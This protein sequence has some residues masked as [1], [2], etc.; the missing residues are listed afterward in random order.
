[1]TDT[2]TLEKLHEIAQSLPEEARKEFDFCRLHPNEAQTI[3]RS[4]RAFDA[5][6]ALLAVFIA[7]VEEDITMTEAKQGGKLSRLKACN[8]ITKRAKGTPRAA[9]HGARIEG[10]YQYICDSYIVARLAYPHHLQLE[11]A[12]ANVEK[13]NGGALI[14]ANKATANSPLELPDVRALN[15]YIKSEKAARKATKD[16]TP[17]LWDFGEG[18]P[19]VNAEYLRDVLEVFPDAIGRHCAGHIYSGIYFESADGAAVLMPVKK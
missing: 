6:G 16:R 15:A 11:E 14:T 18:L 1:M 12:P 2:R 19:A 5:L 8:R 10:E 13:V 7:E 3:A 9:L 17:I 4:R